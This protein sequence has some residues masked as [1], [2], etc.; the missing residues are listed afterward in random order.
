MAENQILPMDSNFPRWNREI[1]LVDDA[2]RR[3]KRW[4]AVTAMVES[5]TLQDVEGLI[6]IAFR[7][8]QAPSSVATQRVREVFH[9]ADDQFEMANNQRELEV[10]CGA[11][12]A[13]LVR[14]QDEIS[15]AAALPDREALVR[16]LTDELAETRNWMSSDQHNRTVAQARKKAERL[17]DAVLRSLAAAPGGEG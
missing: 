14:R 7:S 2:V 15:A 9:S 12:L 1:D 3:E 8:R 13:A 5:A 6:R 11:S 4:T 16:A 10:L 17:T